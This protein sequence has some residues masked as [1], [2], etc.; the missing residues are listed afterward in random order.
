M[1]LNLTKLVNF[2]RLIQIYIRPSRV[3]EVVLF[4]FGA[5]FGNCGKLTK[6]GGTLLSPQNNKNHNYN[7]NQPHTKDVALQSGKET[8]CCHQN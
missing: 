3:P 2:E 8:A 5:F 1:F 6:Y 4:K 7:N